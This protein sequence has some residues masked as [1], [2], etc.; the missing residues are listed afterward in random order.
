MEL[1]MTVAKLQG[2]SG[3]AS[4]WLFAITFIIFVHNKYRDTNQ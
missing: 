1:F 4:K 2:G 3:D